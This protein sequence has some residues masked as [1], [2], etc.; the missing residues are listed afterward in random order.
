MNKRSNPKSMGP[1]VPVIIIAAVLV[2][3]VVVFV[4]RMG[5]GRT[6]VT[7]DQIDQ[8]V[9]RLAAMESRDTSVIESQETSSSAPAPQ[10]AADSDG[11]TESAAESSASGPAAAASLPE[12]QQ[13]I[14]DGSG[15]LD[16]V[17]IRQKFQNTA[18]MGDSITESIWEYNYLDQDVV[19]SQR[20]LSVVNANDQ[21]ATT[22]A[23][24]PKVVFMAFGSN[25]LESYESN[26]QGFI[27]GYKNQI[28]KLQE[29]LP[30]V[31]IYINCVLPI[32]EEAIAGTPALQYYP[33]YNEALI[34]MCDEFG[35]TFIDNAFIVENNPGLYEPDGQHVLSEYYP[36]W[37]SYMAYIAG[38]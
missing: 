5:Q 7:Q 26:V 16:N 23:M 34:S 9:T 21:V 25:D 35:L 28:R 22:I 10:S 27:D 19:I 32:T 24:N 18:I 36:Q 6:S 12:I 17:T 13:S 15:L 29:A 2:V 14:L 37:L 8:T 38:L 1:F 20:G 30:N 4:N 3:I 33:Q 31:P 11:Q